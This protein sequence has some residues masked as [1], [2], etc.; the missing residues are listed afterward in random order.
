MKQ[1]TLR[2]NI[3]GHSIAGGLTD[4]RH[5]ETEYWFNDNC[6]CPFSEVYRC[7]GTQPPD[8]TLSIKENME[9]NNQ[10]VVPEVSPHYGPCF[11]VCPPPKPSIYVS[12]TLL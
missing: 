11:G 2:V 1:E 10:F 7:V 12:D 3:V 6:K 5:H 4:F 9:C 8:D